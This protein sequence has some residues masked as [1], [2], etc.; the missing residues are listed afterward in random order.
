MNVKKHPDERKKHLDKR[1]KHL[2]GREKH[3]EPDKTRSLNA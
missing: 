3:P 2:D 1:K